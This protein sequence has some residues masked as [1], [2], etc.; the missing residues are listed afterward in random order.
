MDSGTLRG[1]FT[2]VLM[3]TFIA[4]IFWAF[5]RKRAKQF[6]EAANLPFADEEKDRETL[7]KQQD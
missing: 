5:S 2:L 4:L 3:A 1:I 7:Q 6:D